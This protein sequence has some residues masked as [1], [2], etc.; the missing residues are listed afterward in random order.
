MLSAS[1]YGTIRKTPLSSAL[2]TH[3]PSR[4]SLSCQTAIGTNAHS[5]FKI[6]VAVP[7]YPSIHFLSWV[8][9]GLSPAGHQPMAGP[10]VDKSNICARIHTYSLFGAF[11]MH[12]FDAWVEVDVPWENARDCDNQSPQDNAQSFWTWTRNFWIHHVLKLLLF[13][14]FF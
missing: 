5:I 14:S 6:H 13:F 10:H 7:D 1:N 4:K 2:I 11:T 9:C 12:A 3:S 8:N